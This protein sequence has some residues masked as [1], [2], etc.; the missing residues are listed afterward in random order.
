VLTPYA[1]QLGDLLGRAIP[2]GYPLSRQG[3][4]KVISGHS[5]SKSIAGIPVP[6]KKA[7]ESII[8]KQMQ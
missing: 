2:E 1:I 6:D 4:G 8:R 3:N 7:L 5:I